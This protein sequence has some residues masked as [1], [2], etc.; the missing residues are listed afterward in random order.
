MAPAFLKA[1]SSRCSGGVNH[2]PAVFPEPERFD[3]ARSQQGLTTFGGGLHI[4]PGRFV[5]GML[6][7]VMLE[8]LVVENIRLE[9]ADDQEPWLANHLMAHLD[10]LK[11]QVHRM[12]AV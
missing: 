11:V 2:D 10:S 7:K 6:C 8:A 5:A 12:M 1:S 3:A 4:C 9:R